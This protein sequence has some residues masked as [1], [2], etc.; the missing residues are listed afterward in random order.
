MKIIE[1]CTYSS[2]KYF[3]DADTLH[4]RHESISNYSTFLSGFTGVTGMVGVGSFQETMMK[5]FP[6]M[7]IGGF[8]VS[9]LNILLKSQDHLSKSVAARKIGGEYL[10]LRKRVQ[11]FMNLELPNIEIDGAIKSLKEFKE[12]NI[13][14][15][16]RNPPLFYAASFTKAQEGIERGEATY[17]NEEKNE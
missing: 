7:N 14:I 8:T 11:F 6:S 12:T 10:S 9:G 15:D 3:N 17:A 2:K 4:A 1:D 13:D 16:N 5:K